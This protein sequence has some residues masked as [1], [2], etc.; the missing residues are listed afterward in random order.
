M[1]YF[2]SRRLCITVDEQKIAILLATKKFQ[3]IDIAEFEITQ[4][5]IFKSLI[6][7]PTVIQRFLNDFFEKHKI[8]GEPAVVLLKGSLLSECISSDPHVCDDFNG[9]MEWSELGKDLWYGAGLA[10]QSWLQLFLI[11]IN[12]HINVKAIQPR[13]LVMYKTVCVTD[14]IVLEVPANESAIYQT[15]EDVFNQHYPLTAD[16]KFLIPGLDVLFNGKG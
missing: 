10:Y 11:F 12:T 7:N 15:I 6:F 1:W 2:K 16:R 9:I 14:D 13:F 3:I 8:H 5:Q 4:H